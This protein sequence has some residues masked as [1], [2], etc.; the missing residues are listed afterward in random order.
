MREE[1]KGEGGQGGNVREEDKGEE[2]ARR[3]WGVKK[4]KGR[5]GQ[6]ENVGEEGQEEGKE[7]MWGRRVKGRKG[8]RRGGRARRGGWKAVCT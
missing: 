3:E 6:G 2:R 1:G 8:K 4:V 7:G 5:K